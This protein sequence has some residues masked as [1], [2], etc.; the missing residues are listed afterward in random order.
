MVYTP[1]S[2]AALGRADDTTTQVAFNP[3]F[4]PPIPYVTNHRT[5]HTLSYHMKPKRKIR[6]E[7][8]GRETP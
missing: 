5:H 1:P 7:K 8:A 6:G 3:A 2:S 4:S